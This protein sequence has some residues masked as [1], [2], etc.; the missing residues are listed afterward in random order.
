M[1]GVAVEKAPFF[2]AVIAGMAI[3]QPPIVVALFPVKTTRF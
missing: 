2:S 1:A 3:G